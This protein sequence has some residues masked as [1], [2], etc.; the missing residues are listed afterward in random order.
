[1]RS[2]KLRIYRDDIMIVEGNVNQLKRFKDDVKE[3]SGGFECGLSIEGFNEIRVGD[4]IEC[5]ITEEIPA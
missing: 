2:G 3:V 1:M 5:Y 4:V